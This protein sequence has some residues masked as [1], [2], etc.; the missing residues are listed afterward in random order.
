MRFPLAQVAVEKIESLFVGQSARSR[1]TQAPLAYHSR[2]VTRFLQQFGDGYGFRGNGVLA[3]RFD[4]HVAP[5]N[6]MAGVQTGHQ[7][8][9]RRG[10]DGTSGIMPGEAHTPGSQGIDVRRCEIFLT[11]TTQIAVSQ[12][13]RHNIDYIGFLHC[14]RLA[15]YERQRGSRGCTQQGIFNKLSSWIV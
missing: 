11:I 2:P 5:H 10:T 9:A 4:F 13:I 12:I 14:L 6:G 3:F 7:R 15:G 8:T 1:T